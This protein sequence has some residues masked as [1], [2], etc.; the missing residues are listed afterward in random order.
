MC[1]FD[2]RY[3]VGICVETQIKQ[4]ETSVYRTAAYRPAAR[5]CDLRSAD[6]YVRE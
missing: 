6:C 5:F 2:L 1:W 4:R 3:Q